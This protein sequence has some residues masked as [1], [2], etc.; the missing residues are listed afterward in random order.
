[1]IVRASRLECL[2]L[3]F[4]CRIDH[5]EGRELVHGRRQIEQAGVRVATD[6]QLDESLGF[7]LKLTPPGLP[8]WNQVFALLG[9]TEM[10]E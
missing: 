5:R 2:P 7:V 3:V 6:G 9:V 10:R 8:R 1:M 4:W